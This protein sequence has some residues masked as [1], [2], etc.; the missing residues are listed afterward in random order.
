[1]N[2]KSYIAPTALAVFTAIAGFYLLMGSSPANTRSHSEVSTLDAEV[3]RY[4][5]AKA[6]QYAKEDAEANSAKP[7]K[8]ADQI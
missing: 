8:K 2:L 5:S 4:F 1:M 7:V 6:E 3:L